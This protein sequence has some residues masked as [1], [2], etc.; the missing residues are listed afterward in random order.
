MFSRS[1]IAFH[2]FPC[3][4]CGVGT[5]SVII[6]A[7]SYTLSDVELF[8]GVVWACG[9]DIIITCVNVA[10]HWPSGQESLLFILWWVDEII[11]DL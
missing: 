1:G 10:G 3:F 6:E 9:I 7:S 8:P 4:P 11:P 2:H 5:L